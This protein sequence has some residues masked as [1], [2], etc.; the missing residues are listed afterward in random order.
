[1]LAEALRRFSQD[2]TGMADYALESG[3]QKHSAM[4]PLERFSLS[5]FSKRSQMFGFLQTQT[6]WPL[7]ASSCLCL[8]CRG[9]HPQHSL[10]RDL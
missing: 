10:L 1:M 4:V 3:G 8:S 9:Q 6:V 5:T 2:R 7:S